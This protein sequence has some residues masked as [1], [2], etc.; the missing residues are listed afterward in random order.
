MSFAIFILSN[1]YAEYSVSSILG[2]SKQNISQEWKSLTVTTDY[3]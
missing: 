3:V 1:G 2:V